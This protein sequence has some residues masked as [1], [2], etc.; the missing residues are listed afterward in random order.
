MAP[1][2]YSIC[3]TMAGSAVIVATSAR[4]F[5]VPNLAAMGGVLVASNHQSY[6]DPVFIG[7]CCDRPLHF[8][9]RAELFE[10]PVFGAF[11]RSLR[12]HPVR[13]GQPDSTALKTMMRILRAGE[14]VVLFPEGTRTMDGKIG[15]FMPGVGSLA[16]R[17]GVPLL[18][19][20]IEGAFE[21]WPRTRLLPRPARVAVAFGEPIEPNEADGRKLTAMLAGR[22]S[23]LQMRLREYLRGCPCPSLGAAKRASVRPGLAPHIG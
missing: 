15:P 3:Q 17:C 11:I 5:N 19:V 23:T 9:A 16:V 10:V 18:P 12:A 20:C 21:C 7:M 2:H 8:L 22:V 14:P 4:Y 13:V 6:L 1:F